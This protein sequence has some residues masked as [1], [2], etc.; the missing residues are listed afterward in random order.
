[1]GVLAAIAV[2]TVGTAMNDMRA[3]AGLRAVQGQLRV[4]R[5]AAIAKRRVVE[6]QFIGTSAVRS[7]RLEGTTRT[8]LQT[9]FFE[10]GMEFRLTPGVPDTPDAFGAGSAVSFSGLTTVFF[11]PD[12]SLT[13]AQGV[14]VSGTVFLGHQSRPL[15]ARAITVLGPTGRVQGYRWDSRTWQRL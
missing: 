1:M 13:D 10:N 9:V 4:A 6:V 8:I 3:N 5:D 7:T 15:S 11:Q 14:P 2:P 12:G